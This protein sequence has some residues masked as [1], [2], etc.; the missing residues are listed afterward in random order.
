MA[1]PLEQVVGGLKF[2]VA[3]A[4]TVA[5]GCA[6]APPPR[7]QPSPLLGDIMPAWE[8]K[9]LNGNAVSSTAFHGTPFVVTFV[10]VGCAPCE[11][12]LSA[13]QEAYVDLRDIVVVGVFRETDAETAPSVTSKLSVKFPVVIDQGGQIAKKFQ[14]DDVPKTFVIDSHG[15]V[16]WVGGADVTE[17]ILNAAVK[18]AE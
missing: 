15:R 18:A 11:R 6:S 2:A 14:S 9:T 16:S 8:S 5:A 3:L 1:E 7:S 10:A 12:T 13:A 17:D 4:A